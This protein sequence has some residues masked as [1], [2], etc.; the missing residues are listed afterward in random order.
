MGEPRQAATGASQALT[1]S[2]TDF[3]LTELNI[4]LQFA[5]LARDSYLRNLDSDGHRQEA[6]AIHALQTAKHWHP[7]ASPTK[8]QRAIIEQRFLEL[9][10]ALSNL[11]NGFYA[12]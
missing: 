12:R 8:A 4:G 7:R 5:D 10:T 11:E 6:A 9:E 1:A 3:V 2:F